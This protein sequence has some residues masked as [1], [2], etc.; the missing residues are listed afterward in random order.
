MTIL[1]PWPY[2]PFAAHRGAGKLAP[3]N[4]LAAVRLGLQHGYRM[5]EFDVKLTRDGHAILMHDAELA[6]TTNGTGMAGSC[7]LAAVAMLDAGSWHSAPYAGEPVATLQA[8]AHFTLANNMAS[9]VEIKPT[10]G[11]ETLT[12]QLVARQVRK[13]WLGAQP[14]PLLSSFSP[15]SLKAAMIEA[16]DLPR[17]L[18]ADALPDNWQNLLTALGCVSVHLK[19]TSVTQASVQ[20][21]HAAGFRLAV[22]TVNDPARA[23]ELLDW[24]V[25][26][27]ITDAIDLISPT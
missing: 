26:T 5:I 9:N 13:A 18:I 2:P 6:R 17:G 1:P 11:L 10:P 22:W 23:Q 4:T 20:S 7:D 3:E 14:A 21:L 25:D 8:I 24:G 12:G 15:V 16:P 27:V 19:H